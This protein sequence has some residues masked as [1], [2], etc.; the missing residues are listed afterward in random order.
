[1]RIEQLPNKLILHGISLFVQSILSN[2]KIC[3]VVENVSIEWRKVKI[4]LKI[5]NFCKLKGLWKV[6][7]GFIYTV[8]GNV[9]ITLDD[10]MYADIQLLAWEQN[11][12]V[13]WKTNEYNFD[14]DFY[15]KTGV[16]LGERIVDLYLSG[17]DRRRVIVV[18]I[19]MV[20]SL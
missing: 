14:P 13:V 19:Q 15:S 11:I 10:T 3:V 16:R 7:S 6:N 5:V 4:F 8:K 1:L 2:Q 9:K 12:G 20:L 18:V 17:S